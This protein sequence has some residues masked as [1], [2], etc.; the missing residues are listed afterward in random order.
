MCSS[1][2]SFLL[3]IIKGSLPSTVKERQIRALKTLPVTHGLKVKN[4]DQ[5][6]FWK[7]AAILAPCVSPENMWDRDL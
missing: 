3:V 2:V 4:N 5:D 6:E 7:E 1:S